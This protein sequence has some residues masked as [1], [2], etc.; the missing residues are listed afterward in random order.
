MADGN[1]GSKTRR[2]KVGK[3][4]NF[5]ARDMGWRIRGFYDL[6]IA[7]T[8]KAIGGPTRLVTVCGN[9]WSG[10]GGPECFHYP[11]ETVE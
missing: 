9:V 4:Q 1:V 2:P 10:W 8:G 11:Q 6:S 5:E 7:A 3:I